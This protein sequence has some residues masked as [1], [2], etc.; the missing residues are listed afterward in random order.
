MK[1]L[2]WLISLNHGTL[3]V[4]I[5]S[6]VQQPSPKK[7]KSLSLGRTRR[8]LLDGA[9]RR[10][11]SSGE[12]SWKPLLILFTFMKHHLNEEGFSP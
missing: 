9:K 3:Q 10:R 12:H 1:K 2:P 7:T 11:S 5:P 8:S 4:S 6:F